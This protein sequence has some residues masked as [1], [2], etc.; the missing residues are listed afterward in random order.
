VI[1]CYNEDEPPFAQDLIKK[2]G[3]RIHFQKGL[4]VDV[5]EGN[6]IPTLVVLDDF[7][8]EASQSKE[9]CAMITRGSSH[10]SMSII[11]TLQ[12]FFYKNCRTL[13][14]NSKYITLFRNPRDTSIINHLSRQ[15]N[16]GKEHP[17]L[18]TA[19]EDAT[20]NKPNSYLFLD[21]SQQQNDD[22][23]IRSNIFPDQSC[24]VYVNRK[25][26]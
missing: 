3:D 5:E 19:Y 11:I 21:M 6:K 7:M 26:Y 15:M 24:I 9:V 2:L 14:L 17:I 25:L 18:K 1:F 13:T 23:R 10:R 16:G 12:N 4:L 20:K 8:E 22:H